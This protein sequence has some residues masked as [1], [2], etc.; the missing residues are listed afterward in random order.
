MLLF[1]IIIIYCCWR[2]VFCPWFASANIPAECM[3]RNEYKCYCHSLINCSP[4]RHNNPCSHISG[5]TEYLMQ[6]ISRLLCASAN[7]C[8]V[9][10]L[11]SIHR[12]PIAGLTARPDPF[13]SIDCS[14]YGQCTALYHSPIN[15][16]SSAL[17]I[18]P[19]WL[20]FL[21]CN[22]VQIDFSSAF[23]CCC[24]FFFSRHSSGCCS[25]GVCTSMSEAH[26]MPTNSK[27][28][29]QYFK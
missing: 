13:F 26:K 7:Y 6:P 12:S 28:F 5:N 14:G 18:V 1:I 19:I 29:I 9:Y 15:Y 4:H 8:R 3:K 24:Y 25:R 21:Y 27:R 22:F 23:F 20:W 10:R 2:T 16:G 17:R 11:R